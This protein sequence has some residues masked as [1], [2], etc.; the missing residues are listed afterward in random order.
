MPQPAYPWEAHVANTQGGVSVTA[1]IGTDGKVV[2]VSG[3]GAS[4]TLVKAAEDN[5]RRWVFGG[6]PSHGEYPIC[7]TIEYRYRLEGQPMAV[8]SPAIV[9]ADL[10]DRLEIVSRPFIND[11]PPAHL[12]PQKSRQ[13]SE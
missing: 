13:H 10:P 1:C 5:A 6:L 2:S 12:V 3:V 4:P 8:I 11:N 9:K 7:H